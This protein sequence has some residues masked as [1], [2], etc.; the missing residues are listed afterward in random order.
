MWT[1]SSNTSLSPAASL[2]DVHTNASASSRATTCPPPATT[3]SSTHDGTS[4]G[5]SAMRG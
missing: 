2:G 4:P 5:P 3:A 1:A